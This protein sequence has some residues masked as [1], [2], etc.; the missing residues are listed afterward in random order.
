MLVIEFH[1]EVAVRQ[2][3]GDRAIEFQQFFFRHPV[4][5]S[6]PFILSEIRLFRD[7]ARPPWPALRR[8]SAERCKNVTFPSPFGSPFPRSACWGCGRPL[9]WPWLP[10]W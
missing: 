3:L 4:F 2:H 8:G 9:C 7:H 5:S 1:P 10:C 6:Y